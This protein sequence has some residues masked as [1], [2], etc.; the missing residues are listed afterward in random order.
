ML[1]RTFMDPDLMTWEVYPSGGA[2]GYSRNPNLVFNCLSNRAEPPRFI[3]VEGDEA[4]AQE[5]V[6]RASDRELLA[7]LQQ[8]SRSD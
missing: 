7:L 5:L 2:H 1:A 6:S 4:T 3:D 8:S